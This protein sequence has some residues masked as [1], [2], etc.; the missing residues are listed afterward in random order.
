MNT[1]VVIGIGLLCFALGLLI[2]LTFWARKSINTIGKNGYASARKM[3]RD[4][5]DE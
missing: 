1:E 5:G 3:L 2:F 4:N